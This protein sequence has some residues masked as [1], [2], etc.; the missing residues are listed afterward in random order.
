MSYLA[1][2]R[3]FRPTTFSEVVGQ[4]HVVT[5]LINQIKTERIGHAYLF[6]GA[7]GTGKTTVAR[8]FARAINCQSPEN[9]SPCGKCEVCTR[10]DGPANLDIIEIDAAS[11]NKV[12]NVQEIRANVQYPPVAGRYKVYIIDE[13]HMLTTEAFN[14]L[15]K[16]LEEPPKHAVF[17]LATTEP[18]KLPA[19][20]LSRCMRFDFHLVSDKVIEDLI[21][22]IYD[23]VGKTYEKEA[24]S[25]IARSGEGSIRDAL[26]LADLCISYSDE[27]LTYKQVIDVLGASDSS[28]TATLL[29]G[30]LNSEV[31]SVLSIIDELTGLGKSVSVLTK[32]VL[33]MVRDVLVVKTCSG[34][35]EVLAL[36]Q[37]EYD[38]L[39][40]IADLAENHRFLR[41]LEIFTA[42]ETDLRYSTHPRIVFEAAAVKAAMPSEDYNVDAL[43]ARISAL[44]KKIEE[45]TKNGVKVVASVD[46][47]ENVSKKQPSSV[48][49]PATYE[50]QKPLDTDEKST[51]K[52]VIEEKPAKTVEKTTRLSGFDYISDE[53]APPIDEAYAPPEE[54]M[55]FT[56]FETAIPLEKAPA[57]E[58]KSAADEK[59]STSSNAVIRDRVSDARL[60]GTIIRKLRSEKHIMLWIACQE[61]DAKVEGDTL[62][63]F[64][65]GEN[66]YNLLVKKESTD[67]LQSI[68]SSLAPYKL[69]IHRVG[70]DE[71]DSESFRRDAEAVKAAFDGKIEIKD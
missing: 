56:S 66:E 4:E 40:E 7:R 39:K 55:S 58:A 9:G 21:C 13:V 50:E 59:P 18:H 51:Y 41:I 63:I 65:E 70:A 71:S 22:K 60:W 46:S 30:I 42:I 47:T 23:E 44:E 29:K 11:N 19:T 26:S 36:P 24:V 52:P 28:K 12:D 10:L 1:I 5:T 16:T 67:T 27:K 35:K 25:L 6:C 2:Y 61:L 3:R 64:A 38:R 20:I 62:V 32:D 33:N 14:A 48:A 15:L 69:K 17:V 43:T 54:Q 49:P 57:R 68:L 31:G 53:D 45:L 37:S 8:I 34:A